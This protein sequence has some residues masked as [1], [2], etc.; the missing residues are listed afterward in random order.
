MRRCSAMMHA[1][2]LGN[3]PLQSCSVAQHVTIFGIPT[4]QNQG[5]FLEAKLL[6]DS[7]L[8]A[9]GKRIIFCQRHLELRHIGVVRQT[10]TGQQNSVTGISQVAS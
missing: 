6:I 2:P 3:S 4:D 7:T 10:R 8:N 5:V 9:D 1:G